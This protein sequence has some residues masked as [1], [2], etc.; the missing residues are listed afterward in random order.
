MHHTHA[1]MTKETALYDVL[2]ITPDA[3]PQDIKKG[4]RKQV[5]ARA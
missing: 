3:T 1:N 4:Y 2:G 5:W